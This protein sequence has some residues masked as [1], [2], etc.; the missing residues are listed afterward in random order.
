M[1]SWWMN[2]LGNSRHK[3]NVSDVI[4]HRNVAISAGETDIES[5]GTP[6]LEVFQLG[7]VSKLA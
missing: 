7:L 6:G 2:G 4:G 3:M 5:L 1:D